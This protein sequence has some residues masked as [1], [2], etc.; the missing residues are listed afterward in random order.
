[1]GASLVAPYVVAGAV[2]LV[3]LLAIFVW[4]REG[5]YAQA[6]LARAARIP[7]LRRAVTRAYLRE[8]EQ[9]NPVAARAYEKVERVSGKRS[10]RH[11]E[12]ALSVLSPDERRAYL[13]LFGDEAEQRSSRR[14]RGRRRAE[15]RVK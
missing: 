9:T 10:P 14:G 4:L 6:L 5:C 12:R 11:T 1:M 2:L 7:A 3:L 13:E 15:K 8:L